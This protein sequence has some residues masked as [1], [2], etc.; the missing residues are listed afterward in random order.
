MLRAGK[1]LEN[2]GNRSN[3]FLVDATIRFGHGNH[4]LQHGRLECGAKCGAIG[5]GVVLAQSVITQHGGTLEYK[6]ALGQG[7]TATILLPQQFPVI[8]AQVEPAP[9]AAMVEARA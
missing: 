4:R 6:S 7:T 3:L 8:Q 9:R 1:V 2:T 5:L